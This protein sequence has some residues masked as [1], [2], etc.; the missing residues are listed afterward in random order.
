MKNIA[1][2]GGNGVVGG[3][4]SEYLRLCGFKVVSYSHAVSGG[5]RHLDV[6]TSNFDDLLVDTHVVIYCAW[7]TKD[8]GAKAQ[9]SH[10]EAARRWATACDAKGIRFLFTSTVL[11][12][13]G[14]SSNYA[15]YKYLAEQAVL[16][17]MGIVL[18]IGL[19]ADDGLPLLLTKIRKTVSK[20]PLLAK[21]ANWPVYVLSANSLG[22]AVKSELFSGP[23]QSLVWVAPL[24]PSRFENVLTNSV[25][26][27][28]TLPRVD[29][30]LKL[31]IKLPI[32]S[33]KIGRYIDA[34]AGIITQPTRDPRCR[35][36]LSGTVP[37][38]NWRE[39]LRPRE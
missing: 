21:L 27:H 33:G 3:F 26:K 19:I 11:A 24:N 29:S 7:N 14:S 6:L 34:L 36:P 9:N 30:I 37:E 25:T 10:A 5:G 32:R 8:R 1:I 28:Q 16:E 12:D 15:K 38:D 4:L 13:K 22:L 23:A 20:F 35:N 39:S 2:F 18:R 17:K 31:I